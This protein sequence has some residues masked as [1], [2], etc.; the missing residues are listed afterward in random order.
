MTD[1]PAQPQNPNPETW[2][3]H[4]RIHAHWAMAM[5][6]CL[7]LALALDAVSEPLVPL[8]RTL[9]WVCAAIVALY[10]GGA[11]VVDGLAKM[12]GGP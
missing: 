3:Y 4:R 11:A 1:E 12:R 7:V 2:W 9:A 6:T 5:L 8:A 10:H